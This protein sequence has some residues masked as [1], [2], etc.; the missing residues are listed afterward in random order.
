MT[1][2]PDLS[3]CDY[4]SR[5]PSFVAVGWID[6][7]GG[8]PAG[9]TAPVVFEKLEELCRNPWQPFAS[10]GYHECNLCQFHN[11][12]FK[13]ELYVPGAGCIYVA[14]IGILHYIGAHRYR[15]PE[16]FMEAVLACPPMR[17]ME[18]KKALLANGG[19]SLVVAAKR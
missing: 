11:A 7:K 15:P 14:P 3:P 19:R 9:E 10:A 2:I 4:V 17:S 18:Y 13:G 12:R 1:G 6:R 8:Y 5:D 16:I